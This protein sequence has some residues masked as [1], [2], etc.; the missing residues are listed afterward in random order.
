[1]AVL[2]FS[3][4]ARALGLAF[5]LTFFATLAPAQAGRATQFAGAVMTLAGSAG[6]ERIGD[7]MPGAALTVVAADGD[8]AKVEITG[9]SP[10]GGAR[11][12]F[13][14][15]SV[16]ISLVTLTDAGAATREVIGTAEDKWGSDWEQVRVSG[17]VPRADLVDDLEAVWDKAGELY[18]SR[19]SRCHSLRRPEE[20][21]AN[22]WPTVLKIMT[23]RAGFNA[24]QAA[25]VTMLLQ[26][27][28]K[29][30]D[31]RD[32]FTA[33]EADHPETQEPEEV[34]IAGTPDLA[35]LGAQQFE[36]LACSACHG[37]DAA[38]PAIEAYPKLAGQN[39]V[40]VYKQ[41]TDFQ[42]GARANDADE[43]MRD[44]VAELTDD[45]VK[46]LA[47]WISLQ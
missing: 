38:S 21:T 16:R 41:I 31:L 8:D 46:A 2:P 13:K 36:D 28:G 23:K 37:E 24:E 9:W 42:S 34:E 39:A 10:A 14:E 5:V 15:V 3:P 6:G 19:C 43:I 18:Y 17:W 33:A 7:V 25:L 20:F 1:M 27:H 45:D 26:Y 4:A 30:Q 22:Q 47:Y 32:A 35:A 29:D 12:L 44:T 11:Y 40:Y